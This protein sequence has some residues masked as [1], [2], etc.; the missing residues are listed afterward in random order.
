MNLKREL[1]KLAKLAQNAARLAVNISGDTKN[2]ILRE[3]AQSLIKNKGAILKANALDIRKARAKNISCA[4]IDRLTLNDARIK[5][6]AGSLLEVAKLKDPIGEELK[7]WRVPSGLKIQKVRVPIGVIAIIYE[8]RPNVTSD[9]IGLCFC[10]LYTS[11]SPR[12]S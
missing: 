9:C 5:D 12:D 10:L 6:M 2:K 11:P 4:F 8:S 3:M 7:S 1:T